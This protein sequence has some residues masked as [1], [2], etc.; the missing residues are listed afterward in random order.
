MT[1][2]RKSAGAPP[3]A[4][5]VFFLDL[6]YH[7]IKN[8]EKIPSNIHLLVLQHGIENAFFFIS[9]FKGGYKKKTHLSI[10]DSF[11]TLLKNPFPLH[12][13]SCLRRILAHTEES[14]EEENEEHLLKYHETIRKKIREHPVIGTVSF[15]AY[16]YSITI[17]NV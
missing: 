14:E 13:K 8:V 12:I 17:S 1:H 6:L 7:S 5:C 11:V 16:I 2:Y 10:R 9:S 4:Q 15:F 3:Q